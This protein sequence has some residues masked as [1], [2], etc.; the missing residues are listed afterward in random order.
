MEGDTIALDF[1]FAA[2][3]CGEA[4]LSGN[5]YLFEGGS[6]SA[7]RTPGHDKINLREG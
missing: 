3:Q 2:L 1:S 5:A 4:C 6:A 7:V